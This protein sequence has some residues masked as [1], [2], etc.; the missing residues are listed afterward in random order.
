M[1]WSESEFST[2]LAKQGQPLPDTTAEAQFQATVIRLARDRGYL[3]YYT[4]NARHSPAGF[5]DLC[6]VDPRPGPGPCYLW[7]LKTQRGKVSIE[8]LTWIAGL[9]GKT[10]D[11]RV[12]RPQDMPN[13]VQWLTGRTS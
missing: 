2:Y 1:H 13:V 4:H 3:V 12:V 7:E 11:A 5:P 10:V 6:I 8:Q 9:H